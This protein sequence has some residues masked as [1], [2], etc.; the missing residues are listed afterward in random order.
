MDDTGTGIPQTGLP[1]PAD[2]ESLMAAAGAEA[3]VEPMGEND[4]CALCYTSGTTGNPKG[5]LYSHRGLYLVALQSAMRDVL[6]LSEGDVILPVV[7]MFHANA[8][9]APYAAALVGATLVFTGRDMSP[10]NVYDL[11]DSERVTM[12]MG[13]PTIWIGLQQY[14]RATG[15]QLPHLERMLSGGSAV[16]RALITSYMEEYGVQ[17]WQ[18]WGMT[19]MSPLGSIVRLSAKMAD[20]QPER[21]LDIMSTA[22]F[23][24]ATVEMKLLDDAGDE[25][26]WDGKSVGELLVRGPSVARDYY[27]H[28]EGSSAFTAD[29]WFRTGDVAS[30]DEDGFLHIS[31]RTKDL[32]KSGGEWISSVE[33]ENAIMAC[34]GVIEAAVVA[35]PDPKWDERPVAFVVREQ[36]KAHPTPDEIIESLSGAFAKWQLP[37][38]DDVHFID[39][40]PRTGVGKFDK[41]VLREQLK[42]A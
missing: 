1:H 38:A 2:Y 17:I 25:L 21:R 40:V 5:V 30:I 35:R 20:W 9:C 41:K 18:G 22:G 39:Q 10:E 3:A 16:P 14:L 12:A 6:G 32:I 7:P 15:K 23:P 27:K 33:M 37:A 34:P 24:V 8:W 11:L 31:D 26:P 36:G 29:G 19:E 28:P 4:A 13:V 42:T